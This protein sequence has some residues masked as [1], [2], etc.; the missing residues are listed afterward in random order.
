[1]KATAGV[2]VSILAW[3]VAA[4]AG[5][6]AETPSAYRRFA[7]TDEDGKVVKLEV[8]PSEGPPLWAK[9][10]RQTPFAWPERDPGQPYFDG[11]IS[12]VRP[13][14]AGSGEVFYGHNHCPAL[15]WCANGDLLA[16]WFSTD[17]EKSTKMT[18]LASRLRAG[19]NEWDT[20]SEFFKADD[21]NMTGSALFHDG[22]GTLYHFNGMG[23]KGV[24]GWGELALLLR[25]STDNG[26]TWT[27]PRAISS[28]ATYRNRHQVIAGTLMM[29]DGTLLQAC[30]ATPGGEGPTALHLSRDHGL[31]WTEAGG[32]IRGIHAGVVELK[33]GR[34]MAFGRGQ[35]IDGR[36]PM[37]LSS[38]L[39][40][41]WSY[42]ATV[43][44]PIGGGQR[45]VLMRLREGPLL[46]VSFAQQMMFKDSNGKEFAG[47]GLYAALS[48]DE[49]KSWPTRRLVT[50]GAGQFDG[51]AWTRRF[52]SAPDRAE[53]KGYLA[54]TQTPDGVVHLISSA[55][56]YR[57][58]LAWLKQPIPPFHAGPAGNDAVDS[59]KTMKP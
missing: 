11:P 5:P 28:G 30:D 19:A 29:R 2:V 40:K 57:F 6:A 7:V 1:M 25:T 32:D 39:G 56:Y 53:P 43:F 58:N 14:A 55:L 49:G 51:G 44:P 15:T 16:C 33:D 50:P 22:K 37:S 36:M 42:Q 38:D 31:T 10:V 54:A 27:P 41:T 9:D 46:F 47:S 13:P 52:T 21:A 20:A 34:L 18:I 35:V 26:A 17:N 8:L 59:S 3:A 24:R 4:P 23:R 48:F 12:F 45:L